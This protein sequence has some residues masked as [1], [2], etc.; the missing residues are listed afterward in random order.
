M[1][2]QKY[3]GDRG[4]MGTDKIGKRPFKLQINGHSSAARSRNITERIIESG[5]E[6]RKYY[7]LHIG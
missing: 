4:E 1:E 5:L 6:R 7:F 2:R 3:G